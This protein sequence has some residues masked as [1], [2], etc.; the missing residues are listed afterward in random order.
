M[1]NLRYDRDRHGHPRVALLNRVL[2][3]Y[4]TAMAAVSWPA[5]GWAAVT[6]D[7]TVMVVPPLVTACAVM[8]RIGMR[9]AYGRAAQA[10]EAEPVPPEGEPRFTAA[11][12]AGVIEG[13]RI[14]LGPGVRDAE[15]PVDDA[16]DIADDLGGG[17]YVLVSPR[18][19]RLNRA[20]VPVMTW[21]VWVMAFIVE[22]AAGVLG[23]LEQMIEDGRWEPGPVPA[24]YRLRCGEL[25]QAEGGSLPA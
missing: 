14:G 16:A 8:H 25:V 4:L 24:L 15:I 21:D 5:F 9:Q 20:G 6:R 11:V 2:G 13:G 22:E 7:W 12:V 3:W 1:G 10:R 19:F 17:P 23:E 18:E